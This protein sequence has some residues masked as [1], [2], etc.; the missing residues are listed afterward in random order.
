MAREIAEPI[1]LKMI[2]TWE[3]NKPD[4]LFICWGSPEERCKG[5]ITKLS[6]DYKSRNLF[7]M[8]YTDHENEDRRKNIEYIKKR[9]KNVGKIEELKINEDN[10]LPMIKE[11]VQKME[12]LVKST[13]NPKIVIDISNPIKWHLLILLK[14]LD[15]RNLLDKIRFLYTEPR[16]YCINLFQPLSF[17]IRE[18][19]PIPTYYGNYDFSKE[20]L[21]ILMLGYEGS[22][23]MALYENV[24]PT[25]TL[26]LVA[27]PSYHPEWENRTEKMNKEIINIVGSSKIKN[28]HSR[29]PLLVAM[30]LHEILSDRKY[31]KYNHI[32][33]PLG[34]KPQTLGLYSFLATNPLNTIL[35]Y[36]APLRH[37]ELFYS[38]GIGRTWELPFRKLELI[39]N[40]R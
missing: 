35:L 13:E 28:I 38:Y 9:L 31:T 10:P 11:I 8:R 6:S 12:N 3:T 39:E 32:I 33:S 23:A 4:E 27:N 37:N 7:I 36:G 19:F 26:L 5:S 29:N 40:E 18:I 14:L 17:G 24:D 20:D 30:Q 1:E 15:L 2:T 34:T 21:L 25:E 16:D 22:R